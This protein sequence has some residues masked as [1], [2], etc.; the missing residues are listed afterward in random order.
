MYL[1]EGWNF[2]KKIL[3]NP[4]QD[5]MIDCM[6]FLLHRHHV[7][8][9]NCVKDC[10]NYNFLRWLLFKIS[11]LRTYSSAYFRSSLHLCVTHVTHVP[12]SL[13]GIFSVVTFASGI[14]FDYSSYSR[15]FMHALPYK[16]MF[17]NLI[18]P[19]QTL[20]ITIE[21]HRSVRCRPFVADNGM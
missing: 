3:P 5:C 12:F 18:G 19:T 10:N 9:I 7:L 4:R 8:H 21:R 15:W 6:I 2:I 16:R 17:K 11:S 14:V 1:E 13:N 20:Q